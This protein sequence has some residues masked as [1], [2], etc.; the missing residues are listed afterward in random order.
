ML[1]CM[2]LPEWP[3]DTTIWPRQRGLVTAYSMAFSSRRQPSNVRVSGSLPAAPNTYV[4][5]ECLLALVTLIAVDSD[6]KRLR[7][8]TIALLSARDAGSFQVLWTQVRVLVSLL[9]SGTAT[10]RSCIR[11]VAVAAA[12]GSIKAFDLQVES[13]M[14]RRYVCHVAVCCPHQQAL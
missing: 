3:C 11:C 7:I 2:P 5:V 9:C 14:S 13:S 8:S 1:K 10:N 12:V 6:Q 4:E